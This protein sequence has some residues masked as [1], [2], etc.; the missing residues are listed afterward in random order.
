MTTPTLEDALSRQFGPAKW[1]SIGLGAR[2]VAADGEILDRVQWR[3]REFTVQ[4][5]GKC[6]SSSVAAKQAAERK[7]GINTQQEQS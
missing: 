5:T 2:L 7:H 3:G 6:Y 1:E 4:S